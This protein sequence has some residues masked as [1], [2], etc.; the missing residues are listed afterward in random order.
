MI[1]YRIIFGNDGIIDFEKVISRYLNDGWN[2]VGSLIVI[3]QGDDTFFYRE[4]MRP[5]S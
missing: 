3:I 2:L 4:I 1:E 5:A